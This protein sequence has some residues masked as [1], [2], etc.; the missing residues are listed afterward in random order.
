MQLEEGSAASALQGLSDAVSTASSVV[1]AAFVLRDVVSKLSDLLAA[2]EEVSDDDESEES[3]VSDGPGWDEPVA[4]ERPT[5]PGPS[6]K[7]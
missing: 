2:V 6:P 3:S 7:E 4:A 5:S 1:S